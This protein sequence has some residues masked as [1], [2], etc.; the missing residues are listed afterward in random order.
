MNRQ[1]PT[2]HHF[3]HT[4]STKMARFNEETPDDPSVKY[5]SFGAEF[6]P[7]WSNAFRIPWGI[8]HEREGASRSS[9]SFGSASSAG[10]SS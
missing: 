4:C 8:V 9:P 7:S 5:I 1:I 3:T 10:G 2:Y 6:T